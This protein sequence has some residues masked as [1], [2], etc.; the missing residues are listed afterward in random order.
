MKI[1]LLGVGMQGKAALHDLAASDSVGEIIAADK[2]Y[3]MLREHVH[4]QSYGARVVCEP[5]DAQDPAS[6]ERLLVEKPDVVLDL[7]QPPIDVAQAVGQRGQFVRRLGPGHRRL[8]PASAVFGGAFL[9][10]CDTAA[11][12][13]VAPAELPVG[14]ITAFLGAP[15]F[16][17][18]LL[19]K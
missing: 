1:L 7:P 11:R 9:V 10:L 19:R 14:V 2:A 13:V 12:M 16:L 15:F 5:V 18:L 6:I 8:L 4:G 3:D 17:W